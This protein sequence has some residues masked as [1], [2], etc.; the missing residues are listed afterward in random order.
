MATQAGWT[1]Y[2]LILDIYNRSTMPVNAEFFFRVSS[3]YSKNTC[4]VSKGSALNCIAKKRYILP[5]YFFG[6]RAIKSPKCL[7][8]D[9]F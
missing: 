6:V 8:S 5:M 1:V 3:D 7:K 2:I 4:N 9:N